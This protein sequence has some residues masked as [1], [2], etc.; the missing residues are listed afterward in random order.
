L[1]DS[2][3]SAERCRRILREYR[4]TV[5]VPAGSEQE[6]I[7]RLLREVESEGGDGPAEDLLILARISPRVRA[8]IDPEYLEDPYLYADFLKRIVAL[9][10]DVLG[11]VTITTRDVP[12]REETIIELKAGSRRGRIT[13][14]MNSDREGAV[15]DGL[16]ELSRGS[17][18]SF[19]TIDAG[20]GLIAFLNDDEEHFL[21]AKGM[22]LENG[23][24]KISIVCS[25]CKARFEVSADHA[26]ADAACRGCGAVSAVPRRRV[27]DPSVPFGPHDA[28]KTAYMKTLRWLDQRGVEFTE[29]VDNF[30]TWETRDF[31]LPVIA[32]RGDV[33]EILYVA[34]FPWTPAHVLPVERDLLGLYA[35]LAGGGLTYRFRILSPHPLPEET[36]GLFRDVPCCHMECHLRSIYPR[37]EEVPPEDMSGTLGSQG[38]G[39]GNVLHGLPIVTTMPQVLDT[40]RKMIFA[41]LRPDVPEGTKIPERSWEPRMSLVM[42]AAMTGTHLRADPLLEVDWIGEKRFMFSVGLKVRHRQTGRELQDD[43]VRAVFDVYRN[44]RSNGLTEHVLKLYKYLRS[45][46]S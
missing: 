41:T 16:N 13:L 2:P 45:G 28:L 18:H 42:M 37:R 14:G 26:G 11:P 10:K 3:L 39:F 43:F 8:Q 25:G 1:G 36:Q 31:G 19:F 5:F 44:G 17:A 6:L 34:P 24:D 46:N 32:E 20:D 22:T 27:Q 38:F 21:R 12:K 35:R 23:G 33:Q 29:E 7:D 4:G 40:V 30:E 9:A 15:V